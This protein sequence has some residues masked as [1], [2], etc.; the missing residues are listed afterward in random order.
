MV[1]PFE[2]GTHPIKMNWI[3]SMSAISANFITR[4]WKTRQKMQIISEDLFQS[5]IV[6]PW[7][8]L[9]RQSTCSWASGC[10][11]SFFIVFSLWCT[12][13]PK[14]WFLCVSYSPTRAGHTFISHVHGNISFVCSFISAKLE[15]QNAADNVK[16]SVICVNVISFWAWVPMSQPCSPSSFLSL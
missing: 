5:G 12:D 15:W 16:A 7:F 6:L 13:E 8:D 2:H 14:S 1:R 4:A 3:R 11:V 10:F 9:Q